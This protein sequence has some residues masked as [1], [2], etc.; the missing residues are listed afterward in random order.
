MQQVKVYT[1]LTSYINVNASVQ[2]FMKSV[3]LEWCLGEMG[4][5]KTL[6]EESL[7]HYPS[8]PKLWMMRGQ[9]EEQFNNLSTMRDV[10][11][12][13]VCV[14]SSCVC[15]CCAGSGSNVVLPRGS[16]ILYIV[17]IL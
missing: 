6:L 12:Q 13:G 11:N 15:S 1:I 4:Q 17:C 16:N 9:I 5:A 7:K 10:Y 8:F 14:L 3:K 2:V